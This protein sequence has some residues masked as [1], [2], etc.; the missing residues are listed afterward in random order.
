[1]RLRQA[2]LTMSPPADRRTLIR[3][4]TLD[5]LGLPPTPEE[6]EAFLADSSPDAYAKLIERL[7]ASPHYGERWARHWLDV[8]RFAESE[9]YERDMKRE[10]AWPYRD[11]VV[12]SFNE[13]KSYRQFAIEQIAGDVEEPVTRDGIAGVS[14][15]VL[16]P[17][18]FIGFTASNAAMRAVARDDQMEE[19]LGTIGQTFLGLTVNC[20]RCHDHKFDPIPQRDY[21]QLRAVFEG[22][23][24]GERPLLTPREQEERRAQVEPLDLRIAEIGDAIAMIHGAARAK[25]LRDRGQG[26]ATGLPAP[27]A[28]WTFDIDGRDLAGGMHLRALEKGVAIAG[29]RLRISAKTARTETIGRDIREK[30]LEAWIAVRK[31]DGPAPV[32]RLEN[33]AIR[34]GASDGIEYVGKSRRWIASSHGDYRTQHL[35]AAREESAAEELVHLA[36]AWAADDSITLYRN[37]RLYGRYRPALET[38]DGK[39]Q[40]YGKG[41]AF[42]DFGGRGEVEIEEA[43]LY[44]RVLTDD[45]IASSFA[46]GAPSVLLDD[47]LRAAT[48]EQRAARA[49]L[50]DDLAGVQAR[51]KAIPDPQLVY[52]GD[53]KNPEPTM[54]RGETIQPGALSCV[55]APALDPGSPADRRL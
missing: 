35:E 37:G 29:G 25:A 19:M 6:V 12:R 2:S 48:D 53:M 1:Q 7:L 33:E 27:V 21:Y 20:A 46:A 36:V 47:L 17:L 34:A 54:L 14:F 38:P 51:R 32:L 8:V 50:I 42:V 23:F 4:A 26:P 13:D 11:Y 10:N 39:L 31:R 55:R 49:R 52:S 40:T 22:V 3:R 16:G 15:L 28:H 41:V 5:L 24:H 45:Q 9:A 18:D 43:R 44:D 30:T